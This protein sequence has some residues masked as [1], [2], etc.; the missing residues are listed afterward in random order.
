[1]YHHKFIGYFSK[2]NKSLHAKVKFF[3]ITINKEGEHE[4]SFI[5]ILQG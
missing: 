2:K 5:Y 4:L 1:L 3:S